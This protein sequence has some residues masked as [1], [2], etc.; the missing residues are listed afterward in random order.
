MKKLALLF[1]LLLGLNSCDNKKE[2]QLKEREDAIMLREEHFAAK[3]AEYNS[4]LAMRDSL[5]A[6]KHKDTI[7]ENKS[8]PDS[9]RVTWS[10]KMIC[11]ESNCSNY[12]IGDQRSESWQFLSDSTG[13]YANVINN[14]KLVRTFKAKYSG[15]TILLDFATDSTAAARVKMN[16]VLDEIRKNVIKG[17]QTITGKE[18]CTAKFSVELT[19][20]PKQ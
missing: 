6:A 4:L 20:A 14:K 3:E 10:S 16:V 12:V 1:T 15:N 2:Q 13:I 9:L 11:R 19:P 7:A 5:M 18:N 17:T 8:W